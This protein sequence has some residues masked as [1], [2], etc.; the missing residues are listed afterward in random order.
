MI[1]Y[2]SISGIQAHRSKGSVKFTIW[3]WPL[4]NELDTQNQPKYSQDVP[5]RI[6]WTL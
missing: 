2:A 4:S 5:V 3:S 6:K 1:F